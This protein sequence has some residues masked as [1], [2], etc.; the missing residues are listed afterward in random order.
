M[1]KEI[2]KK[3]K[4]WTKEIGNNLIDILEREAIPVAREIIMEDYDFNLN[5]VA[6]PKS[7]L[8]PEKFEDEFR[9]R[10]YEFEYIGKTI[11]GGVKVICPDMS[12]F[13]FMG[14]LRTIENIL[15]GIVGIYVEVSREE[16]I[17]ATKKQTYQGR[18]DEMFLIRYTAEVRKW[19]KILDRKFERYPFSNF[20][21]VDIFTRSCQ[22]IE[23]NLDVW[24]DDAINKSKRGI[25]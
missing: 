8:A 4:N 25:K 10:L 5:D 19:E 20:P 13:N 1:N 11:R 18:R 6:N 24:I 2:K 7:R 12:N 15:E 16:Y 9:D 22:Y 3:I 23:E 14:S 17:K 21:P